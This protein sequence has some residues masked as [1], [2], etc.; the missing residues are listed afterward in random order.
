MKSYVAS[1]FIASPQA[2]TN[3]AVVPVPAGFQVVEVIANVPSDS[4][5]DVLDAGNSIFGSRPLPG[6]IFATTANKRLKLPVPKPTTNSNLELVVECSSAPSSPIS[7][8]LV[9]VIE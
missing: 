8:V 6:G 3:R 1:F 5:L 7:V 9:G 4:T 2:G